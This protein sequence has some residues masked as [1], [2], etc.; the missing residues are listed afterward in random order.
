MKN[1]IINLLPYIKSQ[2]FLI[3]K[4]DT[5]LEHTSLAFQ[6]SREAMEWLH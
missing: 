4:E 1:C 3:A 5:T 6:S 2:N